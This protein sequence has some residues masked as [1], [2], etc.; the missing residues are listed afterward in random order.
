MGLQ[1]ETKTGAS[2]N[3]VV[4]RVRKG[5]RGVRS[6]VRRF[7]LAHPS[8]PKVSLRQRAP[9]PLLKQPPLGT[10]LLHRGGMRVDVLRG[11]GAYRRPE[12]VVWSGRVRGAHL[13]EMCRR[14]NESN[15]CCAAARRDRGSARCRVGV[16]LRSDFR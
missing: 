5:Y 14:A 8:P 15:W 1:E 4:I 9:P 12:R 16:H 13:G 2:A 6:R 3:E 10:D 11:G 7:M